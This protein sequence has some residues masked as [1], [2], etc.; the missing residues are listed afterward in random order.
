MSKYTLTETN[1]ND[2]ISWLRGGHVNRVAAALE[3]LKPTAEAVQVEPRGQ[4]PAASKLLYRSLKQLERWSAK[5][6]QWQPEWLPPAGDVELAEDIE[7]Y[8][9]RKSVQVEPV[10]HLH[11]NGDFC[12]EKR[13]TSKEWPVPLFATPQEAAAPEWLPI[14]TA[15]KN[16]KESLFYTEELG[17]V[18][19]YWDDCEDK[20]ANGFG[21]GDI[22]T[23]T[24][25]MPLPKPPRSAA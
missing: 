18:V 23:P 19:M 11:S 4:H 25:W 24:H 10:G 1:L 5:Y 12:C 22:L 3:N 8:L 9:A 20:W 16:G 15:P 2:L 7:E 6:G 21:D 14:E 13:V 17:L